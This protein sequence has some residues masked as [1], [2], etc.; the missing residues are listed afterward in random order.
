VRAGITDYTATQLV[1]VLKGGELKEGDAL[2]TGMTNPNRTVTL[3]ST[4]PGGMSGPGGPG[5]PG[6]RGF[7]RR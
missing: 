7:G 5:G 6:G 2:V 1:Q 4:G 3:G